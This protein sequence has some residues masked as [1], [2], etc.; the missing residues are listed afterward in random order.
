MMDEDAFRRR[1]SNASVWANALKEMRL[2]DS[3]GPTLSID[4]SLGLELLPFHMSHGPFKDDSSNSSIERNVSNS[5][6]NL[7]KLF[8]DPGVLPTPGKMNPFD[9]SNDTPRALNK[10]NS[11]PD[12]TTPM[13]ASNFPNPFEAFSEKMDADGEDAIKVEKPRKAASQD[14]EETL[15]RWKDHI[16]MRHASFSMDP[17]A[18]ATVRT[19]A[20][21]NATFASSIERQLRPSLRPLVQPSAGD[22]TLAPERLPSFG[23]T[24]FDSNQ[25]LLTPNLRGGPRTPTRLVNKFTAIEARPSNKRQASQTL[26]GDMQKRGTILVWPDEDETGSSQASSRRGSG[27]SGTHSLPAALHKT[28][29]APHHNRGQAWQAADAP[30]AC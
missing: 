7:W 9:F 8:L 19:R 29:R 23:P 14:D 5:E 24:A 16:S 18:E 1:R 26:T 25:V 28:G 2:D 27:P 10:S 4:P 13:T 20:L 22:K 3:S 17:S 12:L 15:G 11:A 6:L 30:R 21:T